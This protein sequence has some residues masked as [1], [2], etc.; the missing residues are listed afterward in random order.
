MPMQ[1]SMHAEPTLT[2]RL[3]NVKNNF[4]LTLNQL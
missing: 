2:Q 4:G 1:M 3:R